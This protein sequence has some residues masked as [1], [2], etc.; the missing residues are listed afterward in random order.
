MLRSSRIARLALLIAMGA[1]LHWIENAFP[2][3]IPVPGARLGLANVLTLYALCA[4]GLTEGTYV[5]AGRAFLGALIGGTLGTPASIMSLSG[6]VVAAVAMHLILLLPVGL[7]GTSI[8]GALSHNMT[9][10]SV[11]ALMTLYPGVF[12]YA[13]Y[14]I[15]L[16]IPAG[17]VTGVIAVHLLKYRGS[18]DAVRARLH[19]SEEG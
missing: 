15:L 6:A 8:V 10:L 7:V 9:Q 4:W 2:I 1:V 12:V 11:F 17:L 18:I 13:P 5:A 14:L 3:P 19:S 16:A